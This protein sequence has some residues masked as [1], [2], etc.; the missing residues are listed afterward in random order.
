MNKI[1]VREDKPCCAVLRK[2]YRWLFGTSQINRVQ[3]AIKQLEIAIVFQRGAKRLTAEEL[4]I[5]DEL[6]ASASDNLA[7]NELDNSWQYIQAATRML[8][9]G[10]K[11]EQLKQEAIS[12]KKEAEKLNDWRKKAVNELL[13]VAK[14]VDL[15]AVRK[16]MEIRDEHNCNQHYKNAVR[17]E[18]LRK[19]FG[20]IIV[21]LASILTLSCYHMLTVSA[22]EVQAG[23]LLSVML[24]GALGAS[25][26]VAM[27]LTHKDTS[28]SIPEQRLGSFITWMRPIV[29][30]AA[31]L[32][33][34]IFMAA[35]IMGFVVK[36]DFSSTALAF[37]FIAGFSERFIVNKMSKPLGK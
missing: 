26:S 20:I 30:A 8:L 22:V 34:Y 37:A 24:M 35:E 9:A 5:T 2:I 3:V 4:D 28:A 17:G 31:A 32:A 12:L 14:D 25:F 29:G 1:A 11:P 13:S 6:I 33:A 7:K 21:I 18:S 10:Y 27:S 15:L 36:G 19:V 23:G 16:A